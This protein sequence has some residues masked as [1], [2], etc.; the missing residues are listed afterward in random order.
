MSGDASMMCGYLKK[1]ALGGLFWQQNWFFL[2]AHVLQC[3]KNEKTQGAS[4]PVCSLDA[5]VRC[6]RVDKAI[7]LTVQANNSS[8][9]SSVL[10]LRSDSVNSAMR[11]EQ[12]VTTATAARGRRLNI[13]AKGKSLL[14]GSDAR[15]KPAGGG[16]PELVAVK[17]RGKGLL[18]MAFV[19]SSRPPQKPEPEPE[20]CARDPH[21][22]AEA[23]AEREAFFA[24]ALASAARKLHA[25]VISQ[26]EYEQLVSPMAR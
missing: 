15:A 23:E 20:A 21:A 1:E 14:G 10:E 2:E 6:E 16:A 7:M 9:A 26:G 22:E 4:C 13:V 8:G 18:G 17:G 12:A 24:V 5:I 25:G 19:G 3:S 11:W